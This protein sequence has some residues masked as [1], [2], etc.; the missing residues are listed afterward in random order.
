MKN[1]SLF[2]ICLIACLAVTA[3]DFNKDLAVARTAYKSGKLDDSRF[4][5]EQM[6]QELDMI[7]GKEILKLLPDKMLDQSSNKGKDNVAGASGFAGVIIHR[8]Y[9]AANKNVTLDII[10]NSPLLGTLNALLAVPFI[11]NNGD[12][13]VIKINGYKALVQKVN[14]ENNA[15]NYELQLPLTTSLVTLKAPGFSQ[16]D[17]IKMA[18]TLPVSD[19]VKIIQ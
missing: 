18:N 12:Q 4:A 14:G 3:Q 5:M 6:M 9:G 2:L 1:I 7:T 16:D 8:D 15:V 17:V 11:A 19:S 10:T 13:K